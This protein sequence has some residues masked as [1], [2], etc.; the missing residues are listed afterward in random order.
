MKSVYSDQYGDFLN[1][2]I[3]AR[4]QSRFTQQQLAEVLERP[5]SYVSKYERGERRLD[6]VEFLAIAKA[7]KVDPCS[8]LQR[9]VSASSRGA[10]RRG[11]P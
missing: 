7:L 5:Q 9:V 1:I 4:K 2:M 10:A 11:G 6:V 3:A 8:I